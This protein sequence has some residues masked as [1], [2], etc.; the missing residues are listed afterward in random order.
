MA[1]VIIERRLQAGASGPLFPSETGAALYSGIVGQQ[2]RNR[3]ARLPLDRFSTHDLRRTVATRMAEMG[4]ALDLVAAVI[5]H[6]TDAKD[7]RTLSRHYLRTDLIERKQKA[8]E[9]WD[10][11]LRA[12]I[13]GEVKAA[14]NVV[15]IRRQTG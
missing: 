10:E 3:W 15:E 12:V 6:E 11:R 9:A 14:S 8:L 1:R 13:A 4:I 2:I 7:I 5:G